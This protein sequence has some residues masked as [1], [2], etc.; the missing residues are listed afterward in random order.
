MSQAQANINEIQSLINDCENE[1]QMEELNFQ[2]N[3]AYL[4]LQD[5]DQ[6]NTWTM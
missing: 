4:E 1:A 5:E 2:L 3:A 6:H